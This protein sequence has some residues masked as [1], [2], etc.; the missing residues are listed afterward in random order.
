M[1][2]LNRGFSRGF[3][4]LA[5]RM[6]FPHKKGFTGT[7]EQQIG[8]VF[9]R[10]LI[11][12]V[13]C[14]ARDAGA[15]NL[16][17]ILESECTY[18]VSRRQLSVCGGWS[19]FPALPELPPDVDVLAQV[20]QVLIRCGRWSDLLAHVEPP[21][22]TVLRDSIRPNGALGTWIIP[23][24]NR[25]ATE[26]R[27]ARFVELAWG[28]TEDVEVNANLL[29]ALTLY[30][31]ERF[32][33]I[34]QR[35]L[36]FVVDRQNSNGSWLSSWYFGPYYGTYVC[37]RALAALGDQGALARA[38]LFLV[39]TQR[40]DGGWGDGIICSQLGT[41]LALLALCVVAK[42]L[43]LTSIDEVRMDR[44]VQ[45]LASAYAMRGGWH[46]SPFIRMDVGRPRGKDGPVLVYRSS[47]ITAAYALKAVIAVDEVISLRRKAT[48]VGT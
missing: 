10:A 3:R 43:D 8:D 15:N 26:S 48:F 24:E 36:E 29:F 42:H 12:D 2:Y 39:N 9:A 11:A 1:R 28:D 38:R 25:S 22:L 27:Q 14:D 16:S 7:T 18:L 6:I 5:H 45:A 31:R 21:L 19:Y 4:D 37:A 41:A 17:S 40:R 30:D 44:A 47:A 13:L 35:G 46:G 23:L 20:M 33:Q 32:T 34:L